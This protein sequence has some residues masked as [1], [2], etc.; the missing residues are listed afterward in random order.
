ML[1][2]YSE[3]LA[4]IHGSVRSLGMRLEDIE[5]NKSRRYKQVKKRL[6]EKSSECEA[7]RAHC[8]QIEGELEEARQ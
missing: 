6:S 8:K 3:V 2:N 7:L 4:K 1:Q 5:K